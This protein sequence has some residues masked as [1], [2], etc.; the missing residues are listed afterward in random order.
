[1]Q[2]SQRAGPL[3]GRALT[4]AVAGAGSLAGR[5]LAGAAVLLVAYVA[6]E[7]V[8]FIHEYK[9]VPITPWN[10]GLGL[11]FAFM[12]LGGPRY[13]LLLFIGVL[14]AEL[15]VLRSS[16]DWQ[17]ILSI[18]LIISAGYAAVAEA[19]RRNLRLDVGLNHL[20]DVV[21]LLLAGLA[22]AF[23]VAALIAVVLVLDRQI[24]A[25]DVLVAAW[26]LLV[27][28]V[29]G[30]AVM[31]P[32]VL[33]LALRRRAGLQAKIVPLLLPAALFSVAV[34]LCLWVIVTRTSGFH[35]FYLL[36][37]PVGVAAV[38]YGLDG[39]CLALAF[40][41]FGLVG[42]MH[43]YGY[44]A[45]AF[46]DFQIL[47][48]V[49]SSTGLTV[50]VIVTERQ[51]AAETLQQYEAMLRA[52]EA[53]V[54]QA[55]R[56]SLV[57]GMASTLAH[58][59]NQPMTA[60]RALAR[61]A[62]ELLRTNGDLP[63]AQANLASLISQIDHAG[64]VVRRMRDFL[65]RGR[66]HVSTLDLRVMLEEVRMLLR[67][68]AMERGVPLHLDVAA[69]L[70]VIHADHVQVQQVALNLVG[71]A[72]EAVAGAAGPDPRV[73]IRARRSEEP[74]GVEI[75]VID[76]GPGIIPEMTDRLFEPLATSKKGGL[77]LGLSICA[78]IVES[79]GGRIWLHSGQPGTT[80]F[81]F[82]LPVNGM[83]AT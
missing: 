3:P 43:V 26:P 48:L 22:G 42:L 71:N 38:R 63:R 13:G 7:W 18:S 5:E 47:M 20:V 70:P 74:V 32:L 40:T 2:Q 28:D 25:A 77:G 69:D 4:P 6:L 9:G 46:T 34:A 61:S 31:T 55:A 29:I 19:A 10:P 37:L 17:V 59:I 60:A 24:E 41:Q 1:M 62:Q 67:V 14:L 57:S 58:E 49:L 65:R 76:N 39:A 52:K 23:V 73:T 54:A 83:P 50:G 66:P 30:I 51:H 53:E 35:F 78:T 16:L 79:H 81:R 15:V 12:V 44:D 64:S 11:V 72:I 45:K 75:A 68:Q 8:S 21:V 33:R 56:I 36:F 82:V 80:E 27:G